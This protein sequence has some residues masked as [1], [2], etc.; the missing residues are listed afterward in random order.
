M[1]VMD[2]GICT[3]GMEACLETIGTCNDY[4]YDDSSD[5]SKNAEQTTSDSDR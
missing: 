1:K 4:M 2:E 5:A 3:K